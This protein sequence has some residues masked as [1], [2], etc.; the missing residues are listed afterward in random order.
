[1]LGEDEEILVDVRPHWVFMLGPAALT[2]LVLGGAIA[3]GAEFSS[4][5]IVL[6]YVLAAMVALPAIWLLVRLLSW[7]GVSLVLTN[8]RLIYKRGV[9]RRDYVQLRLQRITEVHCTRG[10]WDRLLGCGRLVVEVEGEHPLVIDDVPRPR[11]LQ[12]LVNDELMALGALNLS[13]NEP[14]SD[15]TGFGPA[16]TSMD[17]W[18]G[19]ATPSAG[20]PSLSSP[21]ERPT[22][23]GS[24]PSSSVHQ[25][26]IELDDLRRRG[27]VSDREF[28]AKKAELLSQI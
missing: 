26:L 18:T 19:E 8:R 7:Y 14:Y 27:I 5:S 20:M 15:M 21:E 28:E 2:L 25:S 3:I 10:I 9:F 17:H 12:R 6:L 22:G 24:A 4:S 11:A 1:M 13:D 16:A 23:V